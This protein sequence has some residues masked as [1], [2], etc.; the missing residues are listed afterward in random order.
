[1]S[2]YKYSILKKFAESEYRIEVELPGINASVS[3]PSNDSELQKIAKVGGKKEAE[4]NDKIVFK[5]TGTG[6][7]GILNKIISKWQTDNSAK[8]NE[9]LEN[10]EIIAGLSWNDAECMCNPGRMLN[11]DRIRSF[12]KKDFQNQIKYTLLTQPEGAIFQAIVNDTSRIGKILIKR[13]E[14][15]SKKVMISYNDRIPAVFTE[16]AFSASSGVNIPFPDVTKIQIFQVSGDIETVKR[17]ASYIINASARLAEMYAITERF[18]LSL[19]NKQAAS[20]ASPSLSIFQ[21]LPE[22]E[23]LKVAEDVAEYLASA[24][25]KKKKKRKT[26][27][28]SSKRK[29]PRHKCKSAGRPR[30]RKPGPRCRKIRKK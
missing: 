22:K 4:G 6:F 12:G 7:S 8:F 29:P 18:R 3:F 30:K 2:F 9:Y 26:T 11:V 25:S 28:K 23:K 5:S 16:G 19:L 27:S 1:M 17:Q 15:F 14:D 21:E 13:I 20:S 24:K 10:A